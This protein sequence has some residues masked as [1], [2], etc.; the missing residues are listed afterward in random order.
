MHTI[1]SEVLEL[2][3]TPLHVL[4]A[5]PS[6]ATRVA[7]PD[8]TKEPWPSLDVNQYMEVSFACTISVPLSEKIVA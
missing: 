8:R 4:I 7:F 6:A 3:V 2:A 1:G 5:P